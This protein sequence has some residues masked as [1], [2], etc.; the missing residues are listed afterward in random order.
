MKTAIANPTNFFDPN[1]DDMHR[2]SQ[3]QMPLCSMPCLQASNSPLLNLCAPPL[4]SLT[5]CA[6]PNR[7]RNMLSDNTLR[8]HNYLRITGAELRGGAQTRSCRCHSRVFPFSSASSLRQLPS[9]FLSRSCL[10]PVFILPR[11]AQKDRRIPASLA[12]R[13]NSPSLRPTYN[14]SG[15]MVR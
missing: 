8:Q 10:R 2:Q 13:E 9:L 6:P 15:A 7:Q 14:S 5:A 4:P 12:S 1:Q 3:R 11:K